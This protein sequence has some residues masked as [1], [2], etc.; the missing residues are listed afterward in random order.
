[1][2]PSQAK[3]RGI[4]VKPLVWVGGDY[5][6]SAHTPGLGVS[7]ET[8]KHKGRWYCNV[9]TDTFGA[10]IAASDNPETAKAAAQADYEARILEALE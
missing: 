8:M 3:E 1:M 2:T 5:F 10:R 4:K 6:C 7:Y 9:V